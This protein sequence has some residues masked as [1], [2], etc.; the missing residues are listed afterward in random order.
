MKIKAL[1]LFSGAG[2][3]ELLLKESNVDVV[4]ANEIIKRPKAVYVTDIPPRNCGAISW[5]MKK[6]R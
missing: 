3:S 6:C 4:I 1:S 5:Q 2:I